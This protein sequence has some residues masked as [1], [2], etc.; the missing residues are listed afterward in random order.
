MIYARHPR[1]G[2][3]LA[4]QR[5]IR[6]AIG[7]VSPRAPLMLWS[8][9]RR[10]VPEL[11]SFFGLSERRRTDNFVA[12]LEHLLLASPAGPILRSGEHV[13]RHTAHAVETGLAVHPRLQL[14]DLPKDCSHLHLVERLWHRLQTT[15]A[16]NR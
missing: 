8:A 15:L 14:D 6:Q 3:R 11:A 5:M 2:E 13:S 4:L 9:Q 7:R 10:T 16:A 1:G 12:C